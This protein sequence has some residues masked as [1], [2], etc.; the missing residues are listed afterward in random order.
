MIGFEKMAATSNPFD[1]FEVFEKSINLNISSD[2]TENDGYRII[3]DIYE[4]CYKL[5][6][7]F[8]EFIMKIFEKIISAHTGNAIDHIND[9]KLLVKG[10]KNINNMTEGDISLYIHYNHTANDKLKEDLKEPKFIAKANTINSQIHGE[11]I[12]YEDSLISYKCNYSDGKKHGKEY[13]YGYHNKTSEQYSY[14]SNIINNYYHDLRHGQQIEI[15]N[16]YYDPK[17][18][19]V[20]YIHSIQNYY[21]GRKIDYEIFY[22]PS[23]YIQKIIHY[24]N[25]KLNGEYIIYEDLEENIKNHKE[26]TVLKYPKVI[27]YRN[28]INGIPLKLE[29]NKKDGKFDQDLIGIGLQ[30]PR[31]DFHHEDT[32]YINLYDKYK[33]IKIDVEY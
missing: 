25:N 9:I 17:C 11:L 7:P 1:L 2:F 13:I 4:S 33:N 32:F 28:Y 8:D 20:N 14:S 29:Q 12:F 6:I 31:K 10:I 30:Y 5:S 21:F 16:Y 24:Y 19:E 27:H 23:G 3:D 15:M 18:N 22:Y 26:T